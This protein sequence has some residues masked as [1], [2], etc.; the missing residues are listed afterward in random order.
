[1]TAKEAAQRVL[2]EAGEPLHYE[3]IMERMLEAGYWSTTGKT[4]QDTLNAQLSVS[5]KEKGDDSP[6]Q[7]VEPATYALS[8]WGLP[9]WTASTP[10]VDVDNPDERRVR[11]PYFPT[12]SSVRSMI[13]I[14][15]GVEKQAYR[16][17]DT[18]IR[19]QTGT[20]QNPVNWS[21]PDTWID[22]RLDGAHAEL[23]RRVWEESDHQINPRY[24]RG[25]WQ[26]LSTYGLLLPGDDGRLRQ[27][28]VGKRF[29]QGDM[30]VVQVL[31]EQEGLGKVL[32]ILSTK[33][34][35]MRGDLLPEW[36]DYLDDVS[37]YNSMSTK[38]DTLRL[39]LG[40]LVDRGLVERDGNTYVIT[41]AGLQYASLFAEEEGGSPRQELQR[42][43]KEHNDTQRVVL[44]D[45]LAEMSP[46]D[47]E[48][49]VRDLL[50]EM[51]Y[52]DVEVT[53]QSGDKGVD[54]VATVQLGITEVKEVVQV[55]RY[56]HT[57]N[58]P[59]IDQLRGALHYHDAIRGTLITL[60]GF[61]QGCKDSAILPGA[62]PISLIDGERLL[63][64]L[65]EHEIGIQRKPAVMYEVDGRYFDGS[66]T[67]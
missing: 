25:Q 26:L 50:E 51:G 64:L 21:D 53:K 56:A 49:L 52:E 45:R 2:E 33:G 54:V 34:R 48:Y 47:F 5:I 18:T 20:P 16:D 37:T 22:E 28:D 7:R 66:V 59:K 55:K 14:L 38:K 58:R 41:D 35:A 63:D 57:V 62:P 1:M 46:N 40:N 30:T 12:Y 39:R 42:A 31:D 27:T 4:P 29:E 65:I 13:R 32:T 17:M 61:S 8:A 36:G 9:E 24:T 10:V 60:S 43:L 19:D 3:T 15:T 23:A 44:R 11:L 6:F 67:D